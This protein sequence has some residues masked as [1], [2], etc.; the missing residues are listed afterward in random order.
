MSIRLRYN[1]AQAAAYSGRH[2]ST[3]RKA[4]EAGELHGG[5]AKKKGRWSFRAECLDAWLDGDSCEH[6]QGSAA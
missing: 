4:A 2:P 6:Q 5:Q 1:V 3:I